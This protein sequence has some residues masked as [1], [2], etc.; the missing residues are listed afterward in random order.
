ML[1]QRLFRNPRHRFLRSAY[2]RREGHDG[3]EDAV[4]A[5]RPV[6]DRLC[7]WCHR[8]DGIGMVAAM[9]VG[10][11]CFFSDGF[12]C[13]LP[14]LIACYSTLKEFA[15]TG[16]R[17]RPRNPVPEVDPDLVYAQIVKLKEKGRLQALSETVVCGAQRLK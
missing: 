3:S 1:P 2:S 5:P 17:G 10:V 13:Y 11:P 14:A 15:R 12:S 9:V 16:K 7:A 8:R 6:W 4:G